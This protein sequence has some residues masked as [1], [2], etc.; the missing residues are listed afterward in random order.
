MKRPVDDFLP[1]E[2]IDHRLDRRMH[3]AAI[4]LFV[5]VLSGVAVAFFVTRSDWHHVRNVRDQISVRYE[6]AAD[7]VRTLT[8][9]ED[10]QRK[11]AERASLAASLIDRLPRSVLLSEFITRMPPGLGLLEFELEAHRV[12]VES[13]PHSGPANRPARPAT[14]TEAAEDARAVAPRW[15]TDISL[16]GFAP[17]DVHVSAFLSALN[18]HPLLQNVTLQ[19]SEETELNELPVRQFRIITSIDPDSDCRA[20][21]IAGAVSP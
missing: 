1:D 11:I 7:Q 6:E 5:V 15:R 13:P 14:S 18:D 16:L 19:F 10:R 12:A 9:L 2:Y 21:T 17:T 20:P 3:L 4:G 8:E